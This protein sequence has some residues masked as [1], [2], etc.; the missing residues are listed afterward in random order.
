VTALF[1]Y[2]M[3]LYFP[4]YLLGLSIRHKWKCFKV[5]CTG[6]VIKCLSVEE[7]LGD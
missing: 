5:K 3:Q 2:S 6:T 4:F 7:G 1:V